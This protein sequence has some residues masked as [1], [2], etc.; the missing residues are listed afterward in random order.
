MKRERTRSFGH[1]L[2]VGLSPRLPRPVHCC[3]V[4]GEALGEHSGFI[5]RQDGYLVTN[6][7]VVDKAERVQIRLADGRRFEGRLVGQD[8]RVDLALVKI[9]ASGSA[10]PRSPRRMR[11]STA[12]WRRGWS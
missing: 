9:E 4:E 1:K 12:S 7:H 10:L 2:V 6:A 5:I 8:N 3:A 11:P